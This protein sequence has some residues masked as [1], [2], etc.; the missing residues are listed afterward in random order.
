[1][2][3]GEPAEPP[4]SETVWW[5]LA[6]PVAHAMVDCLIGGVGSPAP[7]RLPTSIE[8]RVLRRVVEAAADS[9]IRACADRAPLTLRLTDDHPDLSPETISD[10][11]QA[12]VLVASFTVALTGIE[13]TMRVCLSASLVGLIAGGGGAGDENVRGEEAREDAGGESVE[14]SAAAPEAPVPSEELAD[15]APGDVLVTDVD[16]D[17]ELTV[18]VDGREEFGARLG[19]RNGKR[20]VTITRRFEQE[21]EDAQE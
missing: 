21:N 13:G 19:S 18:R 5:E 1:M 2:E 8:R 15:L 6:P 9:F 3:S 14:L 12:T 7:D 11:T 4:A 10:D 17:A 20:A 16:A